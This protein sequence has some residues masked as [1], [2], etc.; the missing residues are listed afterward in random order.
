MYSKIKL[1]MKKL[2]V[3]FFSI[4]LITVVITSCNKDEKTIDEQTIDNSLNV[5]SESIGI[6]KRI[7]G[8]SVSV[9][10]SSYWTATVSG[11]W[12]TISPDQGSGNG[13]ISFKTTVNNTGAKRNCIITITSG[14]QTKII[15][16]TQ[17]YLE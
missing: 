17:G 6:K 2:F 13:S 16:V 1:I 8:A 11:N 9:T 3:L 4:V 5:S 14:G 12:A 7:T 15:S 10:C